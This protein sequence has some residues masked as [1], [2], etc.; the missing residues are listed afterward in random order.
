MWY[1]QNIQD[2]VS[3]LKSNVG[4]GLNDTQVTLLQKQYGKNKIN[5]AKK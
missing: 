5:D 4:T 1:T 3:R 2:V